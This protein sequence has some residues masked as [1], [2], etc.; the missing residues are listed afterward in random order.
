MIALWVL[1]LLLTTTT[2]SVSSKSNNFPNFEDGTR[3]IDSSVGIVNSVINGIVRAI[4]GTII[5]LYRITARIVNV[6]FRICARILRGTRK[7]IAKT[8][9]FFTR[10]TVQLWR[11]MLSILDSIFPCL[12]PASISDIPEVLKWPEESFCISG[13]KHYTGPKRATLTHNADQWRQSIIRPLTSLLVKNTK[14]SLTGTPM[15]AENSKWLTTLTFMRPR[16]L[17]D[18]RDSHVVCGAVNIGPNTVLTTISCAY[19]D[20]T[21]DYMPRY[22]NVK[23]KNGDG[24]QM[25]SDLKSNLVM[26]PDFNSRTLENNLMIVRVPNAFTTYVKTADSATADPTELLLVG[27]APNTMDVA[28]KIKVSVASMEACMSA[29]S[30]KVCNNRRFTFASGGRSVLPGS[31]ALHGTSMQLYALSS[32]TTSNPLHIDGYIR[33]APYSEWLAQY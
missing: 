14:R 15:D 3:M 18:L 6:F 27:R 24:E 28:N 19:P 32:F 17:D 25:V 20:N 11:W 33:V 9:W 30:A 7:I 16:D 4:R 26:H 22:S 31:P 5:T 29:Y 13:V 21:E 10:I 1:A 23:V 8:F 2:S 12:S